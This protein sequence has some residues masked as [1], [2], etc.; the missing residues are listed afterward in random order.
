MRFEYFQMIDRIVALDVD[1]RTVRSVCKVPEKSTIFE[2]HFPNYPLMPGALLLECMAQTTGWLVMAM[3]RFTAMPFLMGVK[4]AKFRTAVFPGDELEFE[5]S[6][7]HEGSG[8]TVAECKGRRQGKAVCEAQITYR[9]IP[10]PSPEFRQAIVRWAESIE[11][12]V[13]ELAK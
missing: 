2:G 10:F 9:V 11:V 4:E 1:G 12:P 7:V 8:F 5:G 3:A 6:I 13:K